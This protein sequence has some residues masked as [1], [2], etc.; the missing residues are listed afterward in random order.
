MLS[1]VTLHASLSALLALF[2]PYFTAPSFHTFGRAGLRAPRADGQTDGVR[3]LT[4]RRAV[5]DLAARPGTL[6]LL[7][8]AGIP[9]TS[10]WR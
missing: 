8:R 7:G 4:R 5:P 9:M 2:A 10:A 6:L 3:L 1:D